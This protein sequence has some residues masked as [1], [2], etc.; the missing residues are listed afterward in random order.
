[1]KL[2]KSYSSFKKAIWFLLAGI[3]F[4]T[5]IAIDR[6]DNKTQITPA[7]HQQIQGSFITHITDLEK[8]V[9]TLINQQTHQERVKSP[10]TKSDFFIHIFKKDSLIYWNTN[11]MPIAP[12]ISSSEIKNGIY[13]LSNGYYYIYSRTKDEII[14][15][16][17][18]LLQSS[19][20]IENEYLENVFN[21]SIYKGSCDVVISPQGRCEITDKKGVHAFFISTTTP[22][23]P[24]TDH[25]NLT[26]LLLSFSFISLLLGLYIITKRQ[27]YFAVITFLTLIFIRYLAIYY[28]PINLFSNQEYQSA[29]LF[30]FN[31][32]SPNI[33][34]FIINV[35][36]LIYGFF[37][38]LNVVKIK[39]DQKWRYAFLLILFIIWWFTLNTIEILVENA[40]VSL[41]LDLPFTLTL[42]SYVLIV[43]V[44]VIFYSFYYGFAIII[45]QLSVRHTSKIMTWIFIISSTI[46]F[47]LLRHHTHQTAT[48]S[49]LLPLI[50]MCL[51]SLSQT[52]ITGNTNIVLQ[53][54]ILALFSSSFIKELNTQ[55]QLK[56]REMR[57]LY[58]TQLLLDRDYE[59]EINY[60][61]FQND[62]INDTV[63][64]SFFNQTE[65]KPTP[66]R[67]GEFFKRSYFSGLWDGYELGVTLFDSS[68]NTISSK[69]GFDKDYLS[70]L[71]ENHSQKSDINPSI[72]FLKESY[73]GY[74]Y[75]IKQTLPQNKGTL[76]FSLKSKKIPEEIGFPRL[77]L[78]KQANVLNGLSKYSIAKYFNGKLAKQH[79][80]FHFPTSL[81]IIKKIS[82][83]SAFID[84]GEYNHY[85]LF[86][87]AGT[88]V[89]LSE[90]T[91]TNYDML[92]SFSYVFCFW[93]LL[94]V[95]INI[96]LLLFKKGQYSWTLAFKIQLM[97]VSLV[98]LS[99]VFFGT[100]SG[101]FVSRQYEL[102]NNKS[103]TD[104]VKSIS[105]ELN[106]K[107]TK[108]PQISKEND[109]LF[110][111]LLTEKLSVI[112]E[113]DINIYDLKGQLVGGSKPEVFSLGLQSEQIN[114][115]AFYE[116]KSKNISLHAQKE[117]IGKLSF[118][119]VY[120]PIY[121]GKNEALGYLNIQ[122]FNKQRD[123]ERQIQSFLVSIMNI[124]ILL[125]TGAII[126][127]L[128]VSNRL[129]QPL[130]Q[131]QQKVKA[132][133]FGQ[134]NQHIVYSSRDEISTIVDAYNNKLDEL[135]EAIKQLKSNERESAWRDMAKQVAHEIKNPLTPIKLSVQQLL[136]VYDA[137]DPASK[138]KIEV[139]VQAIIEQIDSLV[140]I[141]NDFSLF[142]QLPAPNKKETDLIS[143]IN[144]ILPMFLSYN[145]IKISFESAM[146]KCLVTIDKDQ[147]LQVF[148]NLLKNATQACSATK[149]PKINIHLSMEKSTVIIEIKDNGCGITQEQIEKIFTPHF[150][151][152]SK[153]SGIGLSLTKQIIENH[154]GKITFK[155][156]V[157]KG[158]VFTIRLG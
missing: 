69:D 86:K 5:A 107:T 55:N 3:S 25:S 83:I 12:T 26:F 43:I 121:N 6:Y 104:E 64:L 142:A 52:N 151:T 116:L 4:F 13:K 148:N 38:L 58:A 40:D 135:E 103:I 48:I 54:F 82:K 125:L 146:E 118:Y 91:K 61:S 97:S 128:L 42:Y 130:K 32:L 101:L 30:P 45:K 123:F 93:G 72:F 111:E 129:V 53:L 156:M 66:S 15:Q 95:I 138:Q 29:S 21:K 140:K 85:V 109:G 134:I 88:A 139:V 112:F 81:S 89:I 108:S 157:N 41:T 65:N 39:N 141:A 147:W 136:R 132:I 59:A 77:L 56:E 115:L 46:L 11:Q 105:T 143:L 17:S 78:S 155:S 73:L 20:E 34:G 150:T 131:L 44:A 47:A 37:V 144:N 92:T 28:I 36:I 23:N 133:D 117:N 99:L 80:S 79:G 50:L 63:V 152:K 90:K 113:T 51:I 16:G 137:N 71:I 96:T 120:M 98:V 24:F 22:S 9:D 114:P 100:V 27:S 74:S 35:G 102:F 126:I 18:L 76:L 8:Q 57:K 106:N 19:Y 110:F 33:L 119:S 158:T 10:P 31:N 124:F 84:Y 49:I 7:I 149:N 60:T 2:T 67:V 122:H 14:V 87:G 1:L 153:G 127:S 145:N 154:G 68:F 70:D 94:L 75:L 62:L